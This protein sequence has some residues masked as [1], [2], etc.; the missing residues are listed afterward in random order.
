M[1]PKHLFELLD[2][3]AVLVKREQSWNV[4]SINLHSNLHL[5]INELYIVTERLHKYRQSK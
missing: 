4:K 2:V 5:L 3:Q 1:Y